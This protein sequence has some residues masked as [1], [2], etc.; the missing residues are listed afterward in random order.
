MMPWWEWSSVDLEVRGC[1]EGGCQWTVAAS[2]RSV[3]AGVD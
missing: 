1:R 2:E 3:R